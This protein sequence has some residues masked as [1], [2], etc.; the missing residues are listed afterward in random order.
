[1]DKHHRPRLLASSLCRWTRTAAAIFS[2]PYMIIAL[3]PLWAESSGISLEHTVSQTRVAGAAGIH[4]AWTRWTPPFF[5]CPNHGPGAA[6]CLW[7]ATDVT[8]TQT[9]PVLAHGNMATDIRTYLLPLLDHNGGGDPS[10]GIRVTSS[11]P[12]WQTGLERRWTR[13]GTGALWRLFSPPTFSPCW[14]AAYVADYRACPPRRILWADG[15]Q[16]FYIGIP[17][18]S[19]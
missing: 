6:L 1:V 2:S 4:Q 5:C 19:T 9:S 8:W 10:P 16:T 13:H 17:P 3:T 12:V 14:N 15:G 18:P 11:L 7:T